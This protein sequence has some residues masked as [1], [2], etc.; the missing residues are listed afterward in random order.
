MYGFHPNFQHSNNEHAHNNYI[1]TKKS[2]YSMS[3]IDGMSTLEKPVGSMKILMHLHQ[4][5]K[6]TITNLL[7]SERLDRVVEVLGR[8]S[9]YP[10]GWRGR[11]E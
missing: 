3:K 7:K 5:E 1:N 6:A 9:G 2:D 11:K 10:Y 4:H 8:Q